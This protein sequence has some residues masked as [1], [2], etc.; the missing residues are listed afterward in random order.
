MNYKAI[1]RGNG[2]EMP[3]LKEGTEGM[4]EEEGL[5]SGCEADEPVFK[6]DGS[7]VNQQDCLALLSSGCAR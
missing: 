2:G 5:R 7:E 3:K 1:S 4:E 6:D